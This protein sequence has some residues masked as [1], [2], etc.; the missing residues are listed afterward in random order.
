[1]ISNPS[2]TGVGGS[3]ARFAITGDYLY[4]VDHQSLNL[5]NVSKPSEPQYIQKIEMGQGIETIFS[6]GKALFIGSQFGMYIYD[7]TA[8]ASPNLLSNYSHVFSCDPVVADD[9]YAY[10]TLRSNSWCGR[11]VNRLE[12]IDIKNL[13]NPQLV[14]TYPMVGP[15]G[16]AI[17]GNKLFVCDAGLKIYDATNVN[18]LILKNHFPIAADDVISLRGLLMVTG[19]EG[20]TQYDYSN[21]TISFLSKL[22]VTNTKFQ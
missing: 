10:V 1:S 22:Q 18:N 7:I 6:K 21:D 14:K 5:F 12:I 13:R 2:S 15:K 4:T 19:K 17:D 9:N 8:P 20:I 16:L 11:N 3:T